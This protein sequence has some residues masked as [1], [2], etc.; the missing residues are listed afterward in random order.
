MGNRAVVALESMPQVGIYLHWNGGPESISA[1]LTE[2]IVRQYRTPASDPTYAL[3][4]L[5]KVIQ[6]MTEYN[7]LSVG[8]GPLDQ[9]DCDNF[10]NG[11]Y[12]IGDDFCVTRREFNRADAL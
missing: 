5:V 3:A 1:F 4:G 12:W 9:L 8:I 10:D 2:C 11:L 6:D 7:G